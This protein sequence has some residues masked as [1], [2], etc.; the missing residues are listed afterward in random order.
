MKTRI[1]LKRESLHI[2]IL[3]CISFLIVITNISVIINIFCNNL[4]ITF[5]FTI[6]GFEIALFG[7][8]YAITKSYSKK[9]ENNN[10][11]LNDIKDVKKIILFNIYRSLLTFILFFIFK[12]SINSNIILFTFKHQSNFDIF[13]YTI[14]FTLFLYYTSSFIDIILSTIKL[15]N[16]E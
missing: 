13:I 1:T 16:F 14:Q 4:F 15:A 7:I 8:L 5:C 9:F 3:L 6:L 10:Q 12:M 11:I 2:I